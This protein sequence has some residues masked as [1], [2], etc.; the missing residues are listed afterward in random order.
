MRNIS[1]KLIFR[2]WWRNKTFT[3]IS[4]LSLAVGI[5]C[6]NLLTAFVIHEYNIEAENPNKDKMVVAKMTIANDGMNTYHMMRPEYI[7]ELT[8]AV[9]ELDKLCRVL[10]YEFTIYCQVGENKFSDFNVVEADSTFL[11]F[12][13]Q[14]VVMGNLDD[15]LIGPDRIILTESFAK[16]LFGRGDPIGQT[17][18]IQFGMDYSSGSEETYKPFTVSAVVK[19]DHQTAFSFDALYY[20]KP[21]RGL[22]FFLLKDNISIPDLQAKADSLIINRNGMDFLFTLHSIRDACFDSGSLPPPPLKKPNIDLLL[23][24]LFSAILILAIA[25]F[26]YINL[27]FSRVFKQLYSIHVQ[28]LMGAGSR[29]LSI[30]LFADTFMTVGLGFL[31]AQLIQFDLMGV[32]NR[33]MSVRVP[34]SFLYSSQML[35][36]TSVL[37]LLLACIPAL[38][39]SR[40]LPELSISVYNN[41]YRGKARQRIIA[42]LAVVQFIISFVLIIGTFTVRQQI[43]LLY[44]KIENYKDIYSFSVGD[45]QTS[46]LPLKEHIA[47]LPGIQAITLGSPLFDDTGMLGEIKDG[48][49]ETYT[50]EEGDEAI[51]ETMRYTLLQGLPWE[52]AIKQYAHPVYLNRAWAQYLFPDESLPVGKLLKECEPRLTEEYVPVGNDHIIAGVVEN[53]FSPNKENTLETPI[54]KGVISYTRDGICLKV[55]IDPGNTTVIRQIYDE[56]D[57]LHPGG[58]LEHESMYD[59]VLSNNKQLFEL[60]GILMMYSIIS[61]LLI[62]FGLFGISLYAIEQRTKEVGIRKVNGSSTLQIMMTLNRQFIGWIGIA[63]VIAVPVAWLL[64]N[65]WMQSFT[66][67][68]DLNIWSYILSLLIVVG[69]TLLT[70]SWHSYK[71]ATG[72]PV[73]ALRDE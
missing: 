2:S 48:I 32:M 64:L 59:K 73:N 27:S 4:I 23:I 24:A 38:Y 19:D 1:F 22:N 43:S 56:W 17:V 26:N 68:A 41:F 31:I 28:K 29:Q 25:S 20:A 69:I 40:R 12:F 13:P 16:R 42:S 52:E 54:A 61:I 18:R 49:Y 57:K 70:V 65:Q 60:S 50:F 47:H 55:R 15:L 9:P 62:C 14:K 67:Q 34:I 39:M 37:I 35:P 11:Q 7:S 71:A 44:D 6:T 63:Y 21:T 5:A 72:N 3:I 51:M 45:Y 58:Y 30:Q 33:I 66:Y 53:Y 36:A 8:N 46:M 10:P